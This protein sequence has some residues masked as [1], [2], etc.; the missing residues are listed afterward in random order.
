MNSLD[1]RVVGESRTVSDREAVTKSGRLTISCFGSRDS[2][3]VELTRSNP[4]RTSSVELK[5]EQLSGSEPWVRQIGDLRILC[6]ICSSRD[7]Q[8]EAPRHLA[9]AKE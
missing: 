9:R 4:G 6:S 5:T 3:C 7:I 1:R 2:S 8:K